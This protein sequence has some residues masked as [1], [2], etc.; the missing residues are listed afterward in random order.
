VLPQELP[1]H[2]A[3]DG[4]TPL[5]LLF[6]LLLFLLFLLLLSSTHDYCT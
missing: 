1:G 5:L 6:L 3:L 4:M 2:R